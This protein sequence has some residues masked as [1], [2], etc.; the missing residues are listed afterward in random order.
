MKWEHESRF[1]FF[2][3]G[4][5]GSAGF[6]FR[7]VMW[8][9]VCMKKWNMIQSC[10]EVDGKKWVAETWD[11]ESRSAIL[12]GGNSTI[13]YLYPDFCFFFESKFWRSIFFTSVDCQSTTTWIPIFRFEES[14]GFFSL[15]LPGTS[16]PEDCT[17]RNQRENFNWEK[18]RMLQDRW[19]DGSLGSFTNSD[20][21]QSS[22]LFWKEITLKKKKTHPFCSHGKFLWC[23]NFV[24]NRACC[25]IINIFSQVFDVSF[26]PVMLDE[27]RPPPGVS[28]KPTEFHPCDDAGLGPRMMPSGHQ[29]WM[30]FFLSWPQSTKTNQTVDIYIIFNII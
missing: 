19:D 8:S 2:F 26:S 17:Q 27:H 12:G 23:R 24:A 14:V 1:C 5:K 7:N 3:K 11:S 30:I 22:D 10:I 25:V 15:Q 13:L 6:L 9:F 20:T 28:W 4:L 16:E 21:L 18:H 29:Q